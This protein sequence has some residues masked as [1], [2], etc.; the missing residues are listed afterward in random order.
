MLARWSN[1]GSRLRWYE[2]AL[3]GFGPLVRPELALWSAGFLAVATVFEWRAH[4]A[5]R[6][7]GMLAAALALPFAYE[8]F[9]MGY[10]ASLVPN[11]AIAKEAS[12]AYWSSGWHYLHQ[13]LDPYW[14]LVPIVIVVLARLRAARP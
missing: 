2:A 11:S 8:I 10:Y 12:L 1:R 4:G 6:A 5:R 7:L 3:V 13:T 9:R 14:L